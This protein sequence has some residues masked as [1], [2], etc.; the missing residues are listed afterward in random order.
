[1][2]IAEGG[3]G[4]RQ[5]R[6]QRLG[7]AGAFQLFGQRSVFIPQDQARHRLQEDAVFTGNLFQAPNKDPARLVHHLRFNPRR[8]QTDDLVVQGLAIHRSVFVQDDQFDRQAFHAPVGVR[9]DELLHDLDFGGVADPQQDDRRVAGD[10]IA[11]ES[12]LA[13][14]VA[15]QHAGGGAPGGIGIDQSAR[16][17][18]I[19]LGLGLR[20]VEVAQGD[21]AVGPGEV[22]GAVG[23]AGVVIFFDQRQRRFPVFRHSQDEINAG[24]FMGRQRDRA[25]Q[26][27]D[28]I[29][30]GTDG[31]G[32]RRQ[33]PAWRPAGPGSGLVR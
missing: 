1:M 8:D 30:D 22:Q 32:K 28:G 19:K 6:D 5:R 4:G 26:R 24:R 33:P 11:P 21:L 3:A 15:E 18:R 23:H 31:V 13:A 29:Q 12:A 14:P 25:P 27:D 10:A 20:S 2:R 7:A 16:Q 9:L 17:P